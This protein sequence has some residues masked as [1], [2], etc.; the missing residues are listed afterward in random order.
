MKGD[1]AGENI[2]KHSK[3]GH[4]RA[5]GHAASSTSTNVV[6]TSP[7]KTV[8]CTRSSQS[9]EHLP[10]EAFGLGP[11]YLLHN[12]RYNHRTS[13]ACLTDFKNRLKLLIILSF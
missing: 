9:P 3:A 12:E 13:T 7:D 4:S 10:V 8:K 5:S 2:A 11:K 1:F 6:I